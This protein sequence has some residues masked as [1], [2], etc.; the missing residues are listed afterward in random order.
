MNNPNAHNLTTDTLMRI[1]SMGTS[2]IQV[3]YKVY[4]IDKNYDA[5]GAI[6]HSIEDYH[7]GMRHLR[8]IGA[9]VLRVVKRVTTVVTTHYVPRYKEHGDAAN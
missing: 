3:A 1:D 2:D 6:Y 5:V 9:E 4:Y 7:E 8:Q